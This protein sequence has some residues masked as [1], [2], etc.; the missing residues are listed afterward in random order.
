MSAVKSKKTGK[1]SKLMNTFPED[2]LAE[3]DRYVRNGLGPTRCLKYMKMHYHGPIPLPSIGTVEKWHAE[4]KLFFFGKT[5]AAVAVAQVMSVPIDMTKVNMDDPKEVFQTILKF[6]AQR[7]E[8]IKEINDKN[9]AAQYERIITDN[10]SNIAKI[11]ESRIK[12]ES[13]LGIDKAKLQTVMNLLMRHLGGLVVE[14][15][16]EV[17]GAKKL[18]DFSSAL[19]KRQADIP[20]E[21][22]QKEAL[23][24]FTQ[25]DGGSDK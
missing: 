8:K 11:I 15:Y 6:T 2:V 12:L 4:R 10:I 18:D 13:K 19:R 3:L 22:L 7:I 21:E 14:A 9:N 23:D 1:P 25:E 20:F 5:D 16:K 24:A 17:H